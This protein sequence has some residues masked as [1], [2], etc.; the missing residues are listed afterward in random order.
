MASDD[1]KVLERLSI[2]SG[3]KGYLM[4]IRPGIYFLR[5]PE[6]GY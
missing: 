3:Y 5:I 6:T 1:E 2:T 4:G